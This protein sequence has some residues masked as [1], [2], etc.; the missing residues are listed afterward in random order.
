MQKNK[1][2][3]VY[4]LAIFFFSLK[5]QTLSEGYKTDRS[6]YKLD[7]IAL[8]VPEIKFKS[9]ED[10]AIFLT[11]GVNDE[12]SKFRVIYRWIAENIEYNEFQKSAKPKKVLKNRSAVCLGYSNLLTQMCLA[13]GIKCETIIGFSKHSINQI[14][15]PYKKTDHSWNA[16]KLNGHWQLCDVTWSAGFYDERSESVIKKY[17]DTYF[18]MSPRNFIYNHLPKEATW[19]LLDTIMSK[20]LFAKLPFT[21]PAFFSFNLNNIP[22]KNANIKIKLKDTLNFEIKTTSVVDSINMEIVE[23]KKKYSSTF[24]KTP[25]NKYLIKQKFDLPSESEL[26]I[27]MNRRAILAYKIKIVE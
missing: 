25:G 2:C 13:V 21:Y 9:Y 8:N 23:F 19:Q 5:A 24:S 20:S 22:H 4:L 1:T 3:L 11:K 6:F 10:L 14:D 12:F 27:Y 16:V 18:L 15:K 17:S 26:I 7:S